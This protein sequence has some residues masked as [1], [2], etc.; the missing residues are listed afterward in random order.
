VESAVLSG[1]KTPKGFATRFAP[2]NPGGPGRKRKS[3]EDRTF[4]LI[5]QN[6]T[7]EQFIRIW[8]SILDDAEG[9][10]HKD[11]KLALAYLGGLPRAYIEAGGVNGLSDI[12][13]ML[14]GR[15]E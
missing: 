13:T 14:D 15:R 5:S 8:K 4:L 6:T 2:G 9:G 11:R 1:N 12:L 7:D 10:S 3:M